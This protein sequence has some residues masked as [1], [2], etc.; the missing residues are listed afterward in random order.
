MKTHDGIY[1]VTRLKDNSAY[2]VLEKAIFERTAI[3]C[4]AS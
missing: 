4:P 1:F 3:P 2:E